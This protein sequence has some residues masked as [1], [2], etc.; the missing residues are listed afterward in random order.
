MIPGQLWQ[1]AGRLQMATPGPTEPQHGS[2]PAA[3]ECAEQAVLGLHEPY[4]S[5]LQSCYC[6]PQLAQ[7]H[8]PTA[9]VVSLLSATPHPFGLT[10]LF[11]AFQ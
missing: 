4:C 7:G 3:G 5:H 1:A 6:L 2:L 8:G 9:C 11:S 10:A